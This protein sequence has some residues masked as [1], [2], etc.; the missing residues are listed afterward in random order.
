MAVLGKVDIVINQLAVIRG[1]PVLAE[2]FGYP[3]LT[4]EAKETAGG[5]L[6]A[7]AEENVDDLLDELDRRKVRHFEVGYVAE[8]NGNVNVLK[9]AKIVEA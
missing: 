9:N 8:G 4:G 1:T 2:L 7:V 5:M 6:I 3:L